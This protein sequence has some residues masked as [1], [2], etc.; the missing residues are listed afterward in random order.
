MMT[1][2]V[3]AGEMGLPWHQHFQSNPPL[4]NPRQPMSG[5]P[6]DNNQLMAGTLGHM[7]GF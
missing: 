4:A 2:G 7:G 6:I 1:G 5:T 3:D